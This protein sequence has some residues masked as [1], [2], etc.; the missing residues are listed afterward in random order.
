MASFIQV[1]SN[2]WC[3]FFQAIA[4]VHVQYT[5]GTPC[6][7]LCKMRLCLLDRLVNIHNFA[8]QTLIKSFE[9]LLNLREN[10]WP[11]VKRYYRLN[12][13]L[14][15]ASTTDTYNIIRYHSILWKERSK[16]YLHWG[17]SKPQM[18][19]VKWEKRTELNKIP[20]EDATTATAAHD[21]C[22][23]RCLCVC[24]CV[25]GRV[26]ATFEIVLMRKMES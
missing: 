17:K 21:K 26:Y 19:W 7:C 13:T 16:T 10:L 25:L 1:E 18:N 14:A 9:I 24:I 6:A 8:K 23:C 12:L 5:H 2:S 22:T 4:C 3:C 11:N 20:M 15:K